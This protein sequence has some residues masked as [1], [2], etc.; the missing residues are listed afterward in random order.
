MPELSGFLPMIA[1]YA[2]FFGLLW[3]FL[4]RPQKKK[5]EQVMKMRNELKQGD[6]IITIGG[7]VGKVVKVKEDYVHLE[8]IK[9]ANHMVVTKWAIGEVKY[10]KPISK[11]ELEARESVVEQENRV[12]EEETSVNE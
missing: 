3:F 6:E 8:V 7:I 11:K 5:Q 9:G 10:S 1:I 4:I 12:I 2:G